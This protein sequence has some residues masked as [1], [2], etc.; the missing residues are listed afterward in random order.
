MSTI[1]IS[2]LTNYDLHADTEAAS[3]ENRGL[4]WIESAKLKDGFLRY[5]EGL[6]VPTET[7]ARLEYRMGLMAEK[8]TQ[9]ANHGFRAGGYAGAIIRK[10]GGEKYGT[11]FHE[12]LI[13]VEVALHDDGKSNTENEVLA[14]T[15]DN[16]FDR[17][18]DM[19]ELRRHPVDGYNSLNGDPFLPPETKY[20]AGCHHQYEEE[21][22]YGVPLAWIDEEYKDDPEMRD[23]VH[24]AVKVAVAAD[25]YDAATYRNNSYFTEGISTYDYI[26]RRLHKLFPN[27]W[28]DVL[29]ALQEEQLTHYLRA[30]QSVAP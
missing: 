9:T 24:F 6:G 25:I 11:T 12:G 8:D 4:E 18:R 22:P 2:P 1:E 20:I 30:P 26:A 29:E 28:K 15:W 17:N 16:T 27:E 3:L 13:R 5:T 21:E 10:I 7:L 19:P 14:R 23:W